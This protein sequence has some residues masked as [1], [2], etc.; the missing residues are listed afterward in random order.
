MNIQKIYFNL[1]IGY[2][3]LL[4]VS[5]IAM[6]ISLVWPF[7]F[8]R[9]TNSYFILKTIH[10]NTFFYGLFLNLISGFVFILN[11]FIRNNQTRNKS[12][13]IFF[14][15]FQIAVLSGISG[16]FFNLSGK[17]AYFN[18][19]PVSLFLFLV[20]FILFFR[21]SWHSFNQ[22]KETSFDLIKK[23]IWNF[24]ILIPVQVLFILFIISRILPELVKYFPQK[25]NPYV[26][27]NLLQLF[28]NSF[29]YDFFIIAIL[30]G[31]IY[32]TLLGNPEYEYKL[33]GTIE[34]LDTKD[35]F[36]KKQIKKWYFKNSGFINFFQLQWYY[37][38]TLF[39]LNILFKFHYYET[40]SMVSFV[41]KMTF[42]FSP[43][44]CF[45]FLLCLF[46]FI[47]QNPPRPNIQGFLNVALMFL[48]VFCFSCMI[49]AFPDIQNKFM[50]S[51]W[52]TSQRHLLLAGFF[53]PVLYFFLSENF[54]FFRKAGN[55]KSSI[56]S[57]GKKQ[58]LGN[59]QNIEKNPYPF[60]FS[61][62]WI[63]TLILIISGWII[64]ATEAGIWHKTNPNQ[65]LEFPAWFSLME[66]LRPFRIARLVILASFILISAAMYYM[67]FRIT[68]KFLKK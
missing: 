3:I 15:L 58:K 24:F 55:T 10:Q 26:V 4:G 23:Y 28:L 59:M 57:F 16:N 21:I 13:E 19:N 52:M 6:E 5:G 68:P 8:G 7:V 34:K 32:L 61:I 17:F 20:S 40:R 18:L 35:G 31:V 49:T 37:L 41:T 44:S 47:R 63:F 56:T 12:I 14:W 65:Y 53:L 11:P 54:P 30:S 29:I 25:L 1:L 9:G 62:W 39:V 33:A 60:V 51:D 45:I 43:A 64:G 50:F 2:L 46:L 42:W 22:P 48:G 36:F 27:F 66:L 67:I 38:L